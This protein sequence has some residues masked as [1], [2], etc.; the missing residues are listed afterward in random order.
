MFQKASNCDLDLRV[1]WLVK[2]KGLI[3]DA[4]PFLLR[5]AAR[6]AQLMYCRKH[7]LMTPHSDLDSKRKE[8]GGDGD[9]K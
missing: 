8:T 1:N 6:G 3:E 7:P 9:T 2:A 5:K 4:P